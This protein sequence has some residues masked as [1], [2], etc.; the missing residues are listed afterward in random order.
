MNG[1]RATG[2]KYGIARILQPDTVSEREQN[3]RLPRHVLSIS[4]LIGDHQPIQCG[5]QGDAGPAV[6]PAHEIVKVP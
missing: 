4:I 1:S 6:R 2:A 5:V 3:I